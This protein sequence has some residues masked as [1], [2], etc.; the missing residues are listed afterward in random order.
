M[1]CKKKFWNGFKKFNKNKQ[2][3]PQMQKLKLKS[4]IKFNEKFY[5]I[6]TNHF[7]G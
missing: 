7:E 1:G 2:I 6:Y 3:K 4:K 5:F